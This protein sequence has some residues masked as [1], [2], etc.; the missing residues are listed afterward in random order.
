MLIVDSAASVGG[1]W[2]KERLYP[3]LKTNNLVGT[4]EFGDFPMTY[5]GFG[6]KPDT[7]IPGAAVNDYLTQFTE[8][9]DLTSTSSLKPSG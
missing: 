2:C 7:H 8:H 9:F 5:E 4:Y 6:V 1:T 3:G